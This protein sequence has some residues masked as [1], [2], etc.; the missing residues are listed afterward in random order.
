MLAGWAIVC[1]AILVSGSS[2][3]TLAQSIP[4][5]PIFETEIPDLPPVPPPPPPVFNPPPLVTFYPDLLPPPP[6]GTMCVRNHSANPGLWRICFPNENQ[7]VVIGV[8]PP[9]SKGTMVIPPGSEGVIFRFKV[10]F[11]INGVLV[12]VMSDLMAVP[13]P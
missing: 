7:E 3:V 1:L 11:E 2:P 9:F 10:T 6:G 8:I 4:D 13:I 12:T 5:I